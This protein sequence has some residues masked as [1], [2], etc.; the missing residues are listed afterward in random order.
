M[1]INWFTVVAQVINFLILV[2]LLKKF[3]YKPVLDAIEVR[4]KKVAAQLA[5]AETKMKEAK[6]ERDEFQEKNETFGRQRVAQINKVIE[7]AKTERQR[8]LEE[9]RN[10]SNVLRSKLK[11]ELKNEQQN[12]NSE[13]RRKVQKEV[14]AIAGKTLSDIASLSLEQQSVHVFT[15]RLLALNDEEK[16]Q[17]NAALVSSA[18]A[19]SIK[20]AFAL[21]EQQKTEIEKAVEQVTGKQ[22]S[23]KYEINPGLVSGIEISTN[24]YRLSW[25]IAAYLASMEKNV[26]A[27]LSKTNKEETEN[28]AR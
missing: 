24:G 28:V 15:Q 1:E 21:P 4:E 13:I 17:F 23:F 27:F 16:K 7:E 22:M 6:K 10:E 18:N 12:M 5:N 2:W 19:I 26:T 11:E 9:A 25:N 20:S 3:L 14:F 8:L